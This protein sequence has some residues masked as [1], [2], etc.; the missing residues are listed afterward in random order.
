MIKGLSTDIDLQGSLIRP[1]IVMDAGVASQDNVKWL[2]S[3]EYRY[4]VVSRKKR[5][6]IPE[7]VKLVPVKEDLKTGQNSTIK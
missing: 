6:E 3:K 1:T 4:I 7:D 2:R 5:K